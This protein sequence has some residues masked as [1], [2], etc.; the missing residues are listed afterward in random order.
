MSMLL[1]HRGKATR[2]KKKPIASNLDLE[3]HLK[4]VRRLWAKNPRVAAM[5]MQAAAHSL[6]SLDT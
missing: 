4:I 6:Q 2:F 1:E 5:N 3:S